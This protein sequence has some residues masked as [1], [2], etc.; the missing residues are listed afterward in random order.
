VTDPTNGPG[1]N[2]LVGEMLRLVYHEGVAEL[3]ELLTRGKLVLVGRP[4]NEAHL[5]DTY[6][7]LGDPAMQLQ[8]PQA[9]LAV[10]ISAPRRLYTGDTLTYTV[11][12]A[13]AG[14][15][16]ARGITLTHALPQLAGLTVATTNITDAGS[17]TFTA[18]LDAGESGTLTISGVI[19]SAGRMD[20]YALA[21]GTLA[22][23]ADALSIIAV[24]ENMTR[25]FNALE[26]WQYGSQIVNALG[27]WIAIIC[28]TLLGLRIMRMLERSL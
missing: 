22:D 5:L 3:G 16:A 26:L 12:L 27:D 23:A 1:V 6:Q 20:L 11:T 28:G 25:S 19:S 21:Q 13:N 10:S 9:A 17:G 2:L 15:L 24:Y 18:D 4:A 14:P 7:L 8:L